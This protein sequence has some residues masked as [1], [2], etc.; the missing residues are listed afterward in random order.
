M[1]SSH[2]GNKAHDSGTVRRRVPL[3][4][5]RRRASRN[6]SASRESSLSRY[7]LV[8][9]LG[10]LAWCPDVSPRRG[11]VYDPTESAGVGLLSEMSL[12]E[13]KARLEAVKRR[14]ADEEAKKRDKIHSE[15]E[16]REASM[17]E[18]QALAGGAAGAPNGMGAAQEETEYLIP[19]WRCD[20]V[21]IH[22]PALLTWQSAPVPP[23]PRLAM[24]PAPPT[25]GF[26]YKTPPW[27][28]SSLSLSLG[29]L[30]RFQSLTQQRPRRIAVAS[31][32]S[33]LCATSRSSRGEG[34]L[35]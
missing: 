8:A 12:V 20:A 29:R 7:H 27:P 24:F 9:D 10:V 21:A 1:F 33:A 6:S 34:G 35:T 13:T 5:P 14:Q 28:A 19:P 4:T 15:R 22:I 11:K 30:A 31:G 18:R 23:C 3:M 16:E 2:L 17:R 32:V 26:L 25:M